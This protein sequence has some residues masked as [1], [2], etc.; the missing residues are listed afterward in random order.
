MKVYKIV[1]SII[2]FDELGGEE[3]CSILENTH[4]PNHCI[5]PQVIDIQTADC[6]DWSDKHPLNNSQ[7]VV[8]E[9]KKLFNIS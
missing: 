7:T 8:S 5:S 2:D 6:G 4:F 3:V 9:F 1:V